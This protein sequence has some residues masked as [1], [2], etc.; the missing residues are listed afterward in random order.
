MVSTP[1]TGC[2]RN[3]RRSDL[4]INK[5]P[6][7]YEIDS[8]QRI[9]SQDGMLQQCYGLVIASS[10][11]K[12]GFC[13]I[14]KSLSDGLNRVATLKLGCEWVSDEVYPRHFFIFLQSGLKK[15]F[16]HRRLGEGSHISSRSKHLARRSW[17]GGSVVCPCRL[18]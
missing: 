16:E 14:L 2:G 13:L 5:T 8:R 1:G 6:S 17:H 4:R 10:E 15:C 3:V 11:F 7:T 18:L 9:E 12:E